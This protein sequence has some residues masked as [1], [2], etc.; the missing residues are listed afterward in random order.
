MSVIPDNIALHAVYSFKYRVDTQPTGDVVE[1][2][3][4]MKL[5]VG[6]NPDYLNINLD[7]FSEFEFNAHNW[8]AL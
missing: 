4:G 5:V 2:Y 6:C 3:D 8:W 7:S 1:T